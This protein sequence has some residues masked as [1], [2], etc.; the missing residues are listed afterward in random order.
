MRQITVFLFIF[1]FFTTVNGQEL[2]NVYQVSGLGADER[3]FKELDIKGA[4]IHNIKWV[5]PRKK[6]DLVSYTHRLIPQI[7]T[8]RDV[9]LIG[10]SFGG[11]I[12]QE[13]CRQI[14][15]KKVIIISSAKTREEMNHGFDW[16]YTLQ[17]PRIFP[18]S[19]IKKGVE[20]RADYFF[21][22]RNA[23]ESKLVHDILKDTDAHFLKWSLKA[24]VKWDPKPLQQKV[25][26][27]HGTADRVFP[28]QAI[29]DYIPIEGGTHLMIV[30]RAKEISRIVN[31][32]LR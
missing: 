25:V 9:Y 13:L 26:H 11:I 19:F 31:D 8:T 17:L 32:A 30:N 23:E 24:M 2:K 3:V 15:V 27:I 20:S 6:D 14:K 7:D 4:R 18:A 22:T 12:A 10:V 29:H 16:M 1:I 5:T 21:E 28:A